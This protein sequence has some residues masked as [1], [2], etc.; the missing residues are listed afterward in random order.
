MRVLLALLCQLT[1]SMRSLMHYKLI[2]HKGAGGVS[3]WRKLVIAACPMT[4]AAVNRRDDKLL[5]FSEPSEKNEH[6]KNKYA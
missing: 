3:Q 2:E 1:I 4:S 5:A 6:L